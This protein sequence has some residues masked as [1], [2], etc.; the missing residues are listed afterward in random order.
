MKIRTILPIVSSLSAFA[1]P[2]FAQDAPAPAAAEKAKLADE[3]SKP[4]EA[5]KAAE[6]PAPAAAPAATAEATATVDMGGNATAPAPT[7]RSSL[8]ASPTTKGGSESSEA[9]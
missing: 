3:P 1:V 8:A 4:A 2:V 7:K 5:P 9:S 6:A